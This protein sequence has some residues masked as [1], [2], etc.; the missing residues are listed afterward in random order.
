[1]SL[2]FVG[3]VTYRHLT[4][5]WKSAKEV[6]TAYRQYA[7][8]APAPLLFLGARP[9]S[10]SFYS[11]GQAELLTWTRGLE[12]Q[13]QPAYV[14]VAAT[15]FYSLDFQLPTGWRLLGRHDRYVLLYRARPK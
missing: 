6:V 3:V 12:R 9:Y 10:A 8:R 1:M 5:D 2:T 7:T 15:E 13:E 14:A 4:G 11:A